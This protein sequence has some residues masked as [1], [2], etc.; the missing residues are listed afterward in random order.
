MSCLPAKVDTPWFGGGL[1]FTCTQCGHCC[2]GAPGYVWVTAAEIKALAAR[3]EMSAAMFER[4]HVRKVGSRKS[5]RERRGGDCEFLKRLDDGRAICSVYEDRPSQC[6]TWP[7][8][9]ENLESPQAWAEASCDCP[10]MNN[11]KHH[12]LPVIQAAL[13]SAQARRRPATLRPA[14]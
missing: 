14:R 8:W 7:F 2:S 13:G 11:G 3:F 1:R 10:G 4:R 9:D 6:K 5:L 12:A